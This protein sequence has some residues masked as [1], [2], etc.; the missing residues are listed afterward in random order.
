MI[1]LEKQSSEFGLNFG[2]VLPKKNGVFNALIFWT[3]TDRRNSIN[4]CG[5]D[6]VEKLEKLLQEML[7]DN[8]P[9]IKID[10]EKAKIFLK[11]KPSHEYWSKCDRYHNLEGKVVL[12][13]DA[14]H[15][16]F[17]ISAQGCTAALADV[18]ILDELLEKY[19]NDLSQVLPKF[20]EK[21]VKEGHAASDLNLIA[22]V[23]YHPWFRKIY[24][25]VNIV[26]A[27]I[28][29]QSNLFSQINQT[30][31]KYSELVSKNRFW[32]WLAK[33][34]LKNNSSTT[35]KEKLITSRS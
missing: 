5:V 14:A 24:R 17:S 23:V 25:W 15:N 28:F 29:K 32:I 7:A 10:S 26:L 1:R 33:K 22:L 4:P 34:L 11:T 13:G 35:N 18:I 12:I 2:A 6:T 9:Q 20:S 27:K 31:T 30:S 21:Q 8:I 19:Q 16:M 3:P